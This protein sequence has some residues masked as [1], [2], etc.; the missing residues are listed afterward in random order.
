MVLG[1]ERA[2]SVPSLRTDAIWQF[3]IENRRY[4]VKVIPPCDCT[5]SWLL[6]GEI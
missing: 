5:R 1:I 2:Q 4:Q 3:D 6:Y